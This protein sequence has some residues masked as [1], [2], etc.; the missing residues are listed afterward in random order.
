MRSGSHNDL[1]GAADR[2]CSGIALNDALGSR[3]LGTAII[4]YVA[5]ALLSLAVIA[6]PPVMGT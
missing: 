3:P 6:N 2:R 1:A 5:L 4:G